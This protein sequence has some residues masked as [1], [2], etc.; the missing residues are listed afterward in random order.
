M[1]WNAQGRFIASPSAVAPGGDSSGI[2]VT[3][4]IYRLIRDEQYGSAIR[5]LSRQLSLTPG[6]R[7]LLSLL[8]YSSYQTKNFEM[9]A[10]I[11][12]ELSQRFPDNVTYQ[13]NL[14]QSLLNLGALE[15]ADAFCSALSKA[16][17]P[18]AY[19]AAMLMALLKYQAG[20]WEGLEYCLS[21]NE[22][23]DHLA[24]TLRGGRFWKEKMFD[25]ALEAFQR[26]MKT[27]GFEPQ[28]AYNIA[29]CH[30]EQRQFVS[31]LQYIGEIAKMAMEKHPDL[32]NG[33][34]GK[35][36]KE[37]SKI[38]FGKTSSFMKKSAL[39]EAFNLRRAIDFLV[40]KVDEA[41]GKLEL[42]PLRLPDTFDK[43]TIHNQALF[44]SEHNAGA[45]LDKL[46]SLVENPPCLPEVLVN[47]AEKQNMLEKY[48]LNDEIAFLE[49]LIISKNS[50]DVALERLQALAEQHL[51]TLRRIKKSLQVLMAQANIH[52]EQRNY[53]MV[54]GLLQHSSDICELDSTWKMNMAHVLFL[55]QKYA[56]AIWYYEQSLEGNEDCL[57]MV[58]S[59]VLANLCTA[60]VHEHQNA[61][62]KAIL[63][64]L[65]EEEVTQIKNAEAFERTDCAT[66]FHS[67]IVK[68][69]IGTL[70]CAEKSADFGLQMVVEA[71]NPLSDKLRL[72]TW[73]YA[74]R[75]LLDLSNRLASRSCFVADDTI[76]TV[77][78]FL[79]DVDAHA[80]RYTS[81]R[82]FSAV[83]VGYD[84]HTDLILSVAADRC[85]LR[86][87]PTTRDSV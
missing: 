12:K 57:H 56:D 18:N 42:I 69:A 15:E 14:A 80:R 85:Y 54:E 34:S 75:C 44:Q 81:G 1:S 17:G 32:N 59:V 83:K 73:Y 60:Y 26:I 71:L 38:W 31:C 50:P 46:R 2:R 19:R 29:L 20:D 9:A 5:I 21:S 72:D 79:Q 28:M 86:R 45:T 52:V 36:G 13:V 4:A 48:L 43:V 23:D 87:R 53:K 58:K 77:L 70:Y 63:D 30:Y 55:Q 84:C 10:D 82:V 35:P 8:G 61:K 67:C 7:A 47:L 37:N 6:N 41:A 51:V 22:L 62:A 40:G 66:P 74:K 25:L 68:L 27:N 16:S 11:Y 24:A 49:A 64:R 39:V 76:V 3:D 65:K 78:K 33:S